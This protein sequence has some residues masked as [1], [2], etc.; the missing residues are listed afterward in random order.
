MKWITLIGDETLT[1]ESVKS[2]KHDDS[3]SC[4]DVYEG[5]FC[6]EFGDDHIFYDYFDVCD[7]VDNQYTET[8]I[9]KTPFNNPHYIL[10]VYRSGE[11]VKKII[12]QSNFLRGV[13]VDNDAGVIV[14]IEEFIKMGMPMEP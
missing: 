6:V 3:I 7:V 1:L 14:P 11:R 2:I 4:H 8:V 13:Y 10:I 5:R 9:S 12:Q